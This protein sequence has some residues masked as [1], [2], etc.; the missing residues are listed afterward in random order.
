M[1]ARY[2]APPG[3]YYRTPTQ[4]RVRALTTANIINPVTTQETQILPKKWPV[5]DAVIRYSIG[6]IVIS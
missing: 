3:I 1:E 5:L 2:N 4:I 6:S